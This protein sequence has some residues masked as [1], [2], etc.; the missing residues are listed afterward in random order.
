MCPQTLHKGIELES[1]FNS[2]HWKDSVVLRA[3]ANQFSSFLKLLLNIEALYSNLSSRWRNVPG[4]T[5]ESGGFSSAVYSQKSEALTV[6]EGKGGLFDCLY[7]SATRIIVLFL[8]VVDA[9]ALNAVRIFLGGLSRVNQQRFLVKHRG[10][11][12]LAA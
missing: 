9:D 5:F 11:I 4:Q 8:E 3:V 6:I 12:N 10:S 7:R 2:Q 1:F